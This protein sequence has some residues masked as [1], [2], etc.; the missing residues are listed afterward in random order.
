MGVTSTDAVSY[1][2][3]DVYKRQNLHSSQ[4]TLLMS[5]DDY[6]TEPTKI[7]NTDSAEPESLSGIN[8]QMSQETILP[9][10]KQ[11][12]D[13]DYSSETTQASTPY[14][15]EPK[16]LL[17]TNQQT[18]QDTVLPINKQSNEGDYTSEPTKTYMP[19][20]SVEPSSL[21]ETHDKKYST[22]QNISNFMGNY[23]NEKYYGNEPET[24]YTPDSSEQ[25]VLAS[26]HDNIYT[27]HETLLSNDTLSKEANSY[28]QAHTDCL[29]YTSR[30]V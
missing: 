6:S 4:E 18:S 30:C 1:T 29:L 5:K 7:S 16:S 10:S 3:L 22:S 19:D 28:T 26:T 25:D 21:A 13:G 11:N 24:A 9:A 14:I 17:G 15:A 2:H 12:V 20:D 23:T 27:R 8:Q